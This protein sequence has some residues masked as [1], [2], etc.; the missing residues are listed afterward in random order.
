MN[1]A[2]QTLA[3][4]ALALLGGI[5]SASA[6]ERPGREKAFAEGMAKLESRHG[7]RLGVTVLELDKRASLSHRGRERFAMCSTFK[8]LLAAAVAARV[9]AGDEQWDRKIAYGKKDLIPW[10]PVTGKEENLKAGFMTV[11]ALCE[12]SMTWSDNTAA[13]LLL[14]TIG[15]PEGLTRYL[16]SIGD[17][18]TRLDRIEPDLNANV[19][20]DERD[21]STPDAMIATMEKLLFGTPLTDASKEKLIGWLVANHTGDKRIRAAMDPAWRTGDKTGTGENG[22]ANDIA[23]VWPEGRK[24]FLIVVFYDA[25]EATPEQRETVIADAAKQVRETLVIEKR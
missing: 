22:A 16:R 2:F 20:G 13:N 7:G 23:V 3:A 14:A 17:A 6:D 5:P 21:T 1:A 24:P 25:A 18:T 15:G 11:D 19:R 12:A 8:F 9:D 10:T 4:I